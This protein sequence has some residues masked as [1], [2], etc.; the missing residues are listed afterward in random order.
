M[1]VTLNLLTGGGLNVCVTCFLALTSC[2]RFKQLAT[3]ISINLI[4][5]VANPIW[6]QCGSGPGSST[7]GQSGSAIQH[8]Q[9][10]FHIN[11]NFFFY[12]L[13][14]H[15]VGNKSLPPVPPG[16]EGPHQIGCGLFSIGR[17][18]NHL[19]GSDTMLA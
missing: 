4:R 6:F 1:A 8:I 9:D 7:L 17:K 14:F 19:S 13:Y 15:P 3:K 16:V 12:S 18:R 2:K 10:I 5:S 11:H